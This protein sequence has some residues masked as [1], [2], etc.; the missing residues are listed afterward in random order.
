MGKQENG[1][2]AMAR[3]Q[4]HEIGSFGVTIFENP[5]AIERDKRE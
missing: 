5:Q 3:A 2:T 4:V 1:V